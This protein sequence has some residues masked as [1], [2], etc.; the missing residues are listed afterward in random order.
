[1]SFFRYDSRGKDIAIERIKRSLHEG[2]L[3]RREV[4]TIQWFPQAHR[5]S[6]FSTAPCCFGA[7]DILHVSAA[8]FL[9]ADGF[10]T[11][12]GNQRVLAKSEGLQ[13]EP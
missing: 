13:V 4:P 8:L 9:R 6:T 12:D 10:L 5:I 1:M 2:F 11:F 7:L 3:V